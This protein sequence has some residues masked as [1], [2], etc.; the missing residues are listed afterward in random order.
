MRSGSVL[1]RRTPLAR[2]T[3]PLAR[4]KA[5]RWAPSSAERRFD[6]WVRATV[7]ERDG[8]LCRRCSGPGT[9][10]AHVERLGA[11]AS[12]YDRLDIRN[13]PALRVLLCRA[14]HVAIDERREWAWSDIGLD[15]EALRV[16]AREEMWKNGERFVG[17]A[18]A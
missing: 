11:G 14:D 18:S 6:A 1:V 10:A 12:R 4:T 13:Y 17:R 9:D 3:K 8:G 2:G 16:E 15:L 5:K 7:R